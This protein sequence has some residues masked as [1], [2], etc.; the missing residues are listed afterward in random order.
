MCL[1]R[2]RG[3]WLSA[4]LNMDKLHYFFHPFVQSSPFSAIMLRLNEVARVMIEEEK[5]TPSSLSLFL[6]LS[7]SLSKKRLRIIW[8]V[9]RM[10]TEFMY[11]EKAFILTNYLPAN[12]LCGCL[13]GWM[14]GWTKDG[15]EK[16]RELQ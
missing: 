2:G 13:V 6:L 8:N 7:L 12:L 16:R 3:G 15:L 14:D 9:C 5:N 10:G 4:R 11:M 1:R